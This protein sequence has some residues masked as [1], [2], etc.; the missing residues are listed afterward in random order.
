MAIVEKVI[1]ASP[2]QVFDVLADGWTYSDWVVG[3]AHV[4]DVD[5]AWPRVGSQLHHRAG[6]WPFSLQDA[7]TV[8]ACEPPHRLVLRAGLWPAGEAIVAFTLE[9][10]DGGAATRVRIG[11]DFAAGPLRWIRT[12][13]N[14]LVLHL[15]NRETLNRLSDIATRQKGQR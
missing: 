8:L 12:K 11:E 15:R 13:V 3:T 6:P 7:S 14:D 9:P 5:D 1:A 10:V 2:Q 4:R